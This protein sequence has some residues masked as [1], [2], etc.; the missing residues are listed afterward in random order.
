M[1]NSGPDKLVKRWLHILR[2]RGVGRRPVAAERALCSRA[3]IR[4]NSLTKSGL[5]RGYICLHGGRKRDAAIHFVR[6]EAVNL[7]SSPHDTI[8][9]SGQ[10]GKLA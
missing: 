5:L 1:N 6:T 3:E 7:Y 2:V 8:V 4:K 10:R 9:T